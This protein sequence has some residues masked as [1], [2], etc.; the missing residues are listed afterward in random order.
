MCSKLA[1]YLLLHVC[2]LATV[3]A[4]PAS[5]PVR[6][7]SLAS[8]PFQLP[9]ILKDRADTQFVTIYGLF[10]NSL[11]TP[12]VDPSK[13]KLAPI[14]EA[15]MAMTRAMATATGSSV[16]HSATPTPQHKTTPHSLGPGLVARPT[17]VQGGTASSSDTP[18]DVLQRAAKIRAHRL[19][20]FGSVIA[21]I[22]FLGL[23]LFFLLD[24]RMLRKIWGKRVDNNL[25][26]LSKKFYR[27]PGPSWD[28]TPISSSDYVFKDDIS[29]KH[30]SATQK[31][32]YNVNAKVLPKQAISRFSI[33]SSEYPPSSSLSTAE[34]E[35]SPDTSKSEAPPVRPPRP[36]TA[37]SPT[38]S[39]SVY[40][41]CADQPYII[42]AP[43]PFT[44]I[45]LSLDNPLAVP[46]S[47][48]IL[49]P[50]EFLDMYAVRAEPTSDDSNMNTTLPNTTME[51]F[52]TR[53]SRTHSAPMFVGSMNH[54]TPQPINVQRMLK[55]RR[56][57]SASGWAYPN[58]PPSD[59][60][61][62]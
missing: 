45:D 54:D 59:R 43:Q 28:T 4:F 52:D 3:K 1:L 33:C 22:V 41:A 39:E 13:P 34:F 32:P 57:R 15:F 23:L 36:P 19:L 11:H 46:T 26:V 5:P 40:L 35:L 42:V 37:D 38:L 29:E 58:R 49:T 18:Q 61:Y 53:H 6:T 2:Y 14:T 10:D 50:R 21:G 16:M 47:Q 27:R 9:D 7:S 31:V 48:K 24:P 51:S 25:P 12:T 30:F 55:H 44:D 56:S 62:S 20:V 17:S 60:Q 8:A